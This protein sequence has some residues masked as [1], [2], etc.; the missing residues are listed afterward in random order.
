MTR[1]KYETFIFDL[2]DTLLNFRSAEQQA[3]EL[4]FDN[5]DLVLDRSAKKAFSSFNQSLWKKL[6]RKEITR[7]QLF[8]ER[9]HT[10]FKNYF[11]M[12]IDG[13]VCSAQYL[14]YLANGHEE[15]NGASQVLNELFDANKQI[16]LATNGAFKTQI[17]RINDAQIT[18]F[19]EHIFI[20]EKIG[21][22]KPDPGFFEYLFAHSH[23]LPT[24]TLIIGD[25]LSS[26]ILGGINAGIDTAWF[27][28]LSAENYS[29]IK[30]KYQIK[31]L[32]EIKQFT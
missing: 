15:I 30:P 21:V 26:D 17:Q 28:P 29:Q 4:L 10:F 7:T 19:F 23:A 8:E 20:S 9:F 27:N 11:H 25:S 6:E 2:D 18:H 12:E 16:L 32:Y 5:F 14:S 24:K 3:L 1:K 13:N 31:N 22:E